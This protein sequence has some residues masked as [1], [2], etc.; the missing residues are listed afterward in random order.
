MAGSDVSRRIVAQNRKARYN[1][2]VEETLEAGLVLQGTEVRAMRAGH[3]SLG[4]AYA[5][6]RGTEI[7]LVNAH[8]AGYQAASRFNHEPLRPRKLLLHRR[9]IEQLRGKLQREGYTLIPLSLYFNERG[10]AKI[11][12]GLARGRRQIDKRE[13]EKT[14][15]WERQRARLLRADS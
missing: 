15:D 10:R 2:F 4:D 5:D 3:A 6:I 8:I 1:Y 7:F 13:R 14:R 12:L 9:E 11:E